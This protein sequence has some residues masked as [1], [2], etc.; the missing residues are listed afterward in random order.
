MKK[1]SSSPS[2]STGETS[3]T[4]SS[5]S[6]A[7]NEPLPPGRHGRRRARERAR[8][9]RSRGAERAGSARPAAARTS[10]CVT[11]ECAEHGIQSEVRPLSRLAVGAPVPLPPR[12][13]PAARRG[14][15]LPRQAR[16]P[17]SSP[18]YGRIGE[19]HRSFEPGASWEELDRL[20]FKLRLS[21]LERGA[22]QRRR[23]ARPLE[24]AARRP[25]RPRARRGR[26]RGGARAARTEL[27]AA[28]AG[29]RAAA[30]PSSRR[31]PATGSRSTRRAT[32]SRSCSPRTD[33]LRL[34]R[35]APARR[36]P[37]TRR[38]TRSPTLLDLARPRRRGRGRRHGRPLRPGRARG[39]AGAPRRAVRLTASLETRLLTTR[40]YAA[41][42]VSLAVADAVVERLRAAVESTGAT[43]LRRVRR[44]AP[45]RRPPP[46]RR[47]DRRRRH[48]ADRSRASAARCAPAAPTSPRTASTT[49]SR[50]APSR[51]CCSTT[52]PRTAI[53]LEQVAELVEGAAEVCRA[54]GVALVGGETAELPGHLPRGRARLRRHLRRDRRARRAVD[55]SRVAAGDAV[56]GLPSAGVHA[57]GFTLVRRVLE[58]EDYD[59]ADLL[60]PTRLYLD[61]VARAARRAR[62]R[63]RTSPAAASRATSRASCPTGC[64]PSSTG[65]RGSGRRS[66]SGSRATSRRTSCAA[67]STSASATAPSSPTRGERARD[68]AD[69]VIGVLVSGEGTN[70]QALLDAGLP[71]AAVASNRAGARALERAAAAGDPGRGLRPRRPRRAARRA[72]RRWPSWLEEHGVD[73]VVCAGYM[74]LLTPRVPRPLPA[75]DRQ[76]PPVAPARIPRRARDRGRARRGRRRRPASPSTSSTRALDTGPV[77]EQ[78]PVEVEPRETLEQRIH[79]VEHRLLPKVVESE[80]C[81]R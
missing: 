12:H 28:R 41:A 80:L 32:G 69:R 44:A 62:T 63:S 67:S 58:D 39:P 14:G 47:L 71:V 76:R 23:P 81:A 37:A 46:A 22:R 51:C 19:S 5:T 74:H 16:L 54:A 77:I 79:A 1:K 25:H 30:A 7:Q 38:R 24:R 61:D 4:S 65:T 10:S 34:A 57:N 31:T 48:E 18:G 8:A 73:L 36:R 2:W 55:G 59:G 42:G 27:E 68:R 17:S 11:A 45:A 21:E 29:A 60:A 70:L 26:V 35:A 20:G 64:A 72:T 78:Q 53:E 40:T 15:A 33:E 50:P 43:R 6:P 75:A 3:A 66:S 9:A 13:E 52:S 56:V 49:C